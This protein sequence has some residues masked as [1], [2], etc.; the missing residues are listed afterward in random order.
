MKRHKALLTG[1]VGAA[2]LV[3]GA[4]VWSQN[5]IAGPEHDGHQT[6]KRAK[7]GE[8]APDFTLTDTEGVEHTLSDLL[9]TS[10]VVVLEWFNPDCPFIKAHHKT[11]STM[12]NL[13]ADFKDR[14]V[15]WFAINSGGPGK[16]GA[17]VEHNRKAIKDYHIKY[18]ILLDETGEVGH[19]YRAKTTPHMFIISKN[20]TLLYDGAIDGRMEDMVD[21]NYIR[22]ALE[23]VLSGETVTISKS[24]PYGC[25]VKYA[26]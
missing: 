4:G 17:G 26:D 2:V 24:R 11:G 10:E 19:R 16:E 3:I 20:G 15:A 25:S 22:V 23:Q 12:R 6:M 9:K 14:G 1:F 21:T 18:P 7:V 13:Y 5:V 8:P